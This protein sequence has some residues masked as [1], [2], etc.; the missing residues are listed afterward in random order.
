MDKEKVDLHK[1]LQD[2]STKI[3]KELE[4]GKDI[5]LKVTKTGLKVQSAK[6]STL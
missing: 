5:I 1:E 2:K 3:V 6:V 4:D